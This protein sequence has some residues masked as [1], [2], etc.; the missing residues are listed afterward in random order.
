MS[1]VEGRNGVGGVGDMLGERWV[2]PACRHPDN[3]G[4]RE[5]KQR[6]EASGSLAFLVKHTQTGI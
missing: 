5:A 4:E 1:L 2:A 3:L 6:Q